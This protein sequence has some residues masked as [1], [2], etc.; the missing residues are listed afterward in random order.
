[1]ALTFSLCLVSYP[2][3]LSRCAMA[4]ELFAAVKTVR[5]F[6]C[7]MGMDADVSLRAAVESVHFHRRERL[8]AGRAE[9]WDDHGK[10]MEEALTVALQIKAR[11]DN[12]TVR[13]CAAWA[14]PRV[15][16][17]GLGRASTRV[18]L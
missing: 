18:L 4:L 16:L 15:W 13:A 6:L 7:D 12:A 10:L 3:Y 14:E 9:A 11:K 2:R 8:K 5:D 17:S 1:M